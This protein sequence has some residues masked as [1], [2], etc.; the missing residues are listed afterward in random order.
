MGFWAPRK[1]SLTEVV[2]QSSRTVARDRKCNSNWLRN[3]LAHIT[4]KFRH[5]SGFRC[6]VIQDTDITWTQSLL[7][8]P[9]WQDGHQ[10][11]Q[12]PS[13][14]PSLKR[15]SPGPDTDRLD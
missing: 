8:L 13:S 14:H 4:E 12:A 3:V 10:H 6:G 11:L 5:R 9:W 15:T 7:V 1:W 2:Y